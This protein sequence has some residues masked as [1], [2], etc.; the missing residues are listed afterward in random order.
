MQLSSTWTV[1]AE[2]VTTTKQRPTTTAAW[3]ATLEPVFSFATAVDFWGWFDHCVL[4]S[5]W[6]PQHVRSLRVFKHGVSLLAEDAANAGAGRLLLDCGAL[7]ATAADDVWGRALVFA[8]SGAAGDELHPHI[9]G[10]AATLKRAPSL[11]LPPSRGGGKPEAKAKDHY[12]RVE[13][14]LHSDA[15]AAPSLIQRLTEALRGFLRVNVPITYQPHQ[16]DTA[17]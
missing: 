15:A 10:V 12:V 13:V 6:S 5:A 3:L 14:W 8:V 9:N 4:P 17:K 16:Q 7:D 1:H 2:V 11:P